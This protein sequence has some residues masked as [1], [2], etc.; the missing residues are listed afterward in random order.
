MLDD[1]SPMVV[2]GAF[3]SLASFNDSMFLDVFYSRND[4]KTIK[5]EIKGITDDK[6]FTS[7]I[8]EIRIMAQESKN[9]EVGLLFA[10]DDREFSSE[11][12]RKI[13]ESLD[14]VIRVKAIA[15]LKLIAKPEFFTS[16]LSVMKK[17]PYADVRIKAMEVI[18]TTERDDEVISALSET[19]SDPAQ[20]VRIRAAELL[21]KY[22]KPKALEALLNV[23]DTTDRD[24]REAVTTSIS[25]LLSEE[26]EKVRELAACASETKTGKI[27]MA[28][29]MGKSRKRGSVEFLLNLLEDHD[30]EVRASAIGAIGKFKEKQLINSIEN[31]IFDPNERVRAAAVN[32]ISSIGG[33]RAFEIIGHALQDIDGFVRIRAVIG[34]AKLDTM[35]AIQVLQVRIAKFPEFKNYLQGIL[36]A[37]GISYGD[38]DTFDMVTINIVNELCDIKEM[39]DIFKQS[40]DKEKR[41]HAFR[42]LSLVNADD[43]KELLETALKDPVQDIRNEA[44]KRT[45]NIG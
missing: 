35:K 18:A 44:N 39:M 19:L 27:G 32:A 13:K 25:E 29:M 5:N 34:L 7:I 3:M 16:I 36:F 40:S 12:I 45:I 42:I 20:N 43:N 22:S 37:A 23:L 14:P 30:P 10:R 9:L 8:E 41:L 31:M 24:L 4:I 38:P 11:L 2:A 6:R 15:M 21:G 28:W 17:D 33:D 1:P 26:P